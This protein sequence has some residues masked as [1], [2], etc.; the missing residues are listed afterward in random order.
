MDGLTAGGERV[1]IVGRPRT[2]TELD[3]R[4]LYLWAS[5][6]VHGDV[7][8]VAC[9]TGHG[10]ELLARHATVTGLDSSQQAIGRA[11]ARTTGDFRLATVP[12][13]PFP[14]D[15]FNAVVTF[16]TIE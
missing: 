5:G 1:D 14:N 6:R 10:S 4:G 8:D 2:H 13:I 16:E 15:T 12:P 9:G 11:A 7:L 3:H